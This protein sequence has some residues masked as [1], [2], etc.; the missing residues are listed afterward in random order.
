M[1]LLVAHG[2]DPHITT[3]EGTT[4]LMTAAG[5]NWTVAQ[6]YTVSREAILEAVKLNIELGADVNAY[7]SMGLTALHSA[8]NNG[9]NDVI[10]YLVSQGANLGAKDANGRTALSW[11]EGVFLA[12]VG[13]TPKP[14][15][16]ALLKE[17]MSEAG[18]AYAQ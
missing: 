7:N 13:A 14:E 12:A 11:A 3:F 2:A 4:A 10:S 5:A 17:L 9:G 15:T 8:A 18:I 16:I 6:T 1:K